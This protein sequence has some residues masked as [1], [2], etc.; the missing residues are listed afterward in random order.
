MDTLISRQLYL[1][2]RFQFPIFLPSQTL[3]LHIPVSG[4]HTLSQ[5][6]AD[7]FK[8]KNQIFFFFLHSLVIG[9]PK[10]DNWLLGMKIVCNLQIHKNITFNRAT[11]EWG[12]V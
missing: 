7:T 6:E 4:L 2:L 1:R 12:L 10:Y 11:E 8:S 9:H 5:M 3:Y